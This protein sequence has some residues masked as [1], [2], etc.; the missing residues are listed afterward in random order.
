[1]A[2]FQSKTKIY[3]CIITILAVVGGYFLRPTHHELISIFPI[4]N[5]DQ[6]ISHWIKPTDSDYD[7]PLLT[8]EQQKIRMDELMAKYF[9]ARS[10]W[11]PEY[12]KQI[13]SY[14]IQTA[15]QQK[16]DAFNNKNK[17]AKNIQYG[18]NYIPH[19]EQWV[20]DIEYSM[21]LSQL[22][23]QHYEVKRRG[24]AI[25]NLQGRVLPTND[26]AFFSHK[27]AG[28]GYPFDNL[29]AATVWTGTPVYILGETRNH[30][31]Y[32]VHTPNFIA[33]VKSNGIAFADEN[34]VK[35]WQQQAQ[36]NLAA[37]TSTQLSIVDSE[38][39][40]YRFSGYVGMLFPAEND[41]IGMRISI[42]V[43]DENRNARIHHA[44]LT[45]QQAVVVP[46]LPTPHHFVEIINQLI[47]RPYGWGGMYRHNDCSA[48]LKNLFAPFGILLPMHSSNQVDPESFIVK[49]VDLSKINMEQRLA[50]LEKNGHKFMT[51]VH[52]GGHVFL[53]LGNY[54]NPYNPKI[55][56]I[57]TYQAMW[58]LRPTHANGNT[59]NRT[60]IG[61]SVLLPLLKVY[62]ESPQLNSQAN[63]A[64]FQLGYLDAP[65]KEMINK[66]HID[67]Q[68]SVSP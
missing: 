10:P 25:D 51:I 20:R 27:L 55:K 60:I 63:K 32:L 62:P 36:Q 23:H 40:S 48:E 17:T 24:I 16:I 52:V 49:Q 29:Q 2:S 57:L 9:G 26:V 14:D 68:S 50:Y 13:F 3:L 56:N 66:S 30:S 44:Q 46:L 53:Y 19:T 58:G 35:S 42:P 11:S 21:N 22:N 67:L 8:K 45:A 47:G 31:W 28:Q 34:F 18:S 1:M 12:M 33:W 64:V 38:T 39:G 4:Q 7:Q 41:A 15:E 43:A 65:A 61:K 54:T 59:D 6:N 37:I 5:Y